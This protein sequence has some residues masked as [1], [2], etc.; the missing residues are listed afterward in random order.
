MP[1][2]NTTNT[3]RR[4]RGDAVDVFCCQWRP[5]QVNRNVLFAN[6]ANHTRYIL[7]I[8]VNFCHTAGLC[9]VDVR[10]ES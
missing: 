5:A 6:K 1:A 2:G 9:H 7:R 10:V 8:R 4:S 3:V